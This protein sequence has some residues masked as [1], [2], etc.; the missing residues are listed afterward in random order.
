MSTMRITDEQYIDAP[1]GAPTA[2]EIVTAATAHDFQALTGYLPN[3][4]KVLKAENADIALYEG[5][6]YD[7][8][9]GAVVDSVIDAVKSLEWAVD[10]G[11]SKSRYAK[12]LSN[13]LRDWDMHSFIEAM[14]N[15]RLY[16]YQPLEVMWSQVGDLLVPSEA[17]AKPQKWFVFDQNRVLRFRTL[18]D[19]DLGMS[20]EQ[21]PR[22]FLCPTYKG[23]Y[24]NPY[25]T[26]VLS[27]CFWPVTFKRGGLKFWLTFIEKY[28]MPHV[29]IRVPASTTDQRRSELLSVGK[30]MIQDAVAVINDTDAIT[31]VESQSKGASSDLYNRLFT[32]MN[33][34]ISKAIKSETLTTQLGDSGSYAAAKTHSEVSAAGIDSVKSLVQRELNQLVDWYM[35]VNVSE[36]VER[37]RI[38]PYEEEN[39]DKDLAERDKTLVDAGVRLTRTYWIRAYG[40]DESDLEEDAPVV[41]PSAPADPANANPDAQFA[42]PPA[43]F[44]DQAALDAAIVSLSDE[45]MQ[46][47]IETVIGPVLQMVRGARGYDDVRKRL[48]GMF[49][50]M[51]SKDFE[52]TLARVMFIS[53][54]LGRAGA[55]GEE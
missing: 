15:A 55:L 44:P 25:G 24:L 22:K 12:D 43:S 38:V 36:S 50:G 33:E 48:Y 18:D 23:T 19:K 42:D 13:W 9:V 34:E 21:F 49:P 27:R 14:M 39:V 2:V 11:K 28:G 53:S 35:E 26:G 31:L 4:D 3:P 6:L 7:A 40:F 45:E 8:H 51:R 46:E 32:V 30:R 52:E 54:L 5:L 10:R 20:L 16:G 37:P 1:A 29:M 41:E 47:Q 17:I